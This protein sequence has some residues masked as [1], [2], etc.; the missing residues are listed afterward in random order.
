MIDKITTI[1]KSDI[2][3]K[4]GIISTLQLQKVDDAIK[5]WLDID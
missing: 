5:I 3:K 1:Y 2:D 4:I